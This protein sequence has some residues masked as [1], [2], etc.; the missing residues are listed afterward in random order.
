MFAERPAGRLGCYGGSGRF[1]RKSRHRTQLDVLGRDGAGGTQS[2]GTFEDIF[3]LPDIAWKWI[4]LEHLQRAFVEHRGID[5]HAPTESRQDDFRDLRYV[6]GTLPQ[7]R[8]AHFDDVDPVEEVFP[9][10][11]L[12]DELSQVLV[13]RGK[14]SDVDRLLA[15]LANR[16]YRLFLYN[17]QQFDLHVQR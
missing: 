6:L 4:G 5:A 12:L 8:H 15:R 11:A 17:P 2:Q 13:G 3:Q 1:H 10:P 7:R 14:N 9:E 16:P